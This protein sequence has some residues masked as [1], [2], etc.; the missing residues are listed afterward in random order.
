MV[1]K[2]MVKY[3]TGEDKLKAIAMLRDLFNKD[4]ENT[5]ELC[6]PV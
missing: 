5:V 4:K 3:G 2:M 6:S 1:A